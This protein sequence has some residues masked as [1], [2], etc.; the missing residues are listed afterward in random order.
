M[1]MAEIKQKAKALA[2][3]PGKMRKS[4]LIKAIQVKESNFDCF[5]TAGEYC[6]QTNCYWREDCLVNGAS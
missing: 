5:G 2:I 1:I 4:D 6:D 3:K